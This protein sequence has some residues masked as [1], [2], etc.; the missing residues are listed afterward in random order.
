MNTLLLLLTVASTLVLRSGDR[1]AVEG[2]VR[3]EK[4]VVMFRSGGVLYS[5]PAFE[6]ERIEAAPPA[7]VRPK[8]VEEDSPRTLPKR[9]RVSEEERKRILEE[10]QKNR[11]GTPAPKTTP[12]EERY[13]P[14]SRG[15]VEQQR[16][17]EWEWRR[18]ARAYEEA[19]RRAQ[20]DLQLLETRVQ[21]LQYQI[22]SLFSLGYKPH[23]FT[24]QTTQLARMQEKIPAAR[25]EVERAQRAYDQFRED[26][27]RLG[28]L[29]GWLR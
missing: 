10:L 2:P 22:Q 24:Y 6:I 17:E 26:A 28:I 9:L 21:E 20:E 13:P 1:I 4:G 29:P 5:M 23:Q 12:I 19:L 16:R 7:P 27:R 15:E 8:V 25:L 14:P 18:E 3:E 11:A